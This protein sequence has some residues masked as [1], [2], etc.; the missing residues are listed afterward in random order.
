MPAK[1]PAS[2]AESARAWERQSARASA[3][4]WRTEAAAWALQWEEAALVLALVPGSVQASARELVAATAANIIMR[5]HSERISVTRCVKQK[6]QTCGV[7]AGLG[8]GVGASV[9]HPSCNASN[10]PLSQPSVAPLHAPAST[11]A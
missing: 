3:R 8:C 6:E 11:L 10:K 4:G 7:G 5:N 1:A 2:A 9:G